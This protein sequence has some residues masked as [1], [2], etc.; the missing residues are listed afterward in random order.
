[1]GFR[2]GVLWIRISAPPI[3][4]KANARLIEILADKLSI[5][6]KGIR[7][8]RG[9]RSKDKLLEI[10]GLTEDEVFRALGS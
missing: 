1:M 9:E 4:G 8:L 10:E 3:R 6:K 2:Q 7:L 5:P